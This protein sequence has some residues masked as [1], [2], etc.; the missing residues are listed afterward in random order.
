MARIYLD[1]FGYRDAILEGE[2]IKWY[3]EQKAKYYDKRGKTV[4]WLYLYEHHAKSLTNEKAFELLEW[5]KNKTTSEQRERSQKRRLLK[6]VQDQLE[7]QQQLS[8]WKA[9]VKGHELEKALSIEPL[10]LELDL[11]KAH[12]MN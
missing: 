4:Y 7:L 6:K 2:Q 1:E 11:S 10:T 5:L 9:H 12:K 8:I 3:W